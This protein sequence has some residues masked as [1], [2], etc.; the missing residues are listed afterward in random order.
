MRK[1]HKARRAGRASPVLVAALYPS[2]AGVRVSICGPAGDAPAVF[3]PANPQTIFGTLACL[4]LVCW[5]A[6]A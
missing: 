4:D 6:L 2:A 1:A 5:L 3:D